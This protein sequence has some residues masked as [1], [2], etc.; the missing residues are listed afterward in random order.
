M[1]CEYKIFGCK[2]NKYF[3]ERWKQSGFLEKKEG[4]FV[5]SCIVTDQAKARWIRY[6]IKCLNRLQP[7][8]KI[9]LS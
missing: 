3:T 5:A 4:I 8:Q 7:P 2:T 9:Y 6:I 1:G